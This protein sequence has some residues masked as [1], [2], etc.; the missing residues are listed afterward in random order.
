MLR[1]LYAIVDP[2]ACGARG[3]VATAEA[4]LA[5][6]CATLQLR[7]KEAADRDRL[8]LARELARLCARAGTPFVVNDRPDLARLAGADGLHLGQDDVGIDDARAIVGAMP[9]GRS[10]HSMGELASALLEG[11]DLVALGPVFSTASKIH[12]SPVVAPMWRRSVPPPGST[13]TIT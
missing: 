6:G 11:A 8:A 3:P 9:I 5:G 12:P 10:C 13:A 1:G 2:L 4:I 7:W